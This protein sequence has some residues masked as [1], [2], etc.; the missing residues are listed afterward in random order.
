[1]I[2][3]WCHKYYYLIIYIWSNLRSFDSPKFLECLIIWN[4]ESTSINELMNQK[5]L[6][7]FDHTFQVPT[8]DDPM[9]NTTKL[10]F[11]VL[12]FFI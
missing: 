4:G 3:N 11:D 10:V 2:L 6:H 1:M 9:K 12:L 5:S 7:I 8:A